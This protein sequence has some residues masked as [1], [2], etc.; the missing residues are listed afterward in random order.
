MPKFGQLTLYRN[1]SKIAKEGARPDQRQKTRWMHRQ[2]A[3]EHA[4][5]HP[6][7]QY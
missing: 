1:K 4:I 5:V 2:W 7:Q 3:F 6:Q